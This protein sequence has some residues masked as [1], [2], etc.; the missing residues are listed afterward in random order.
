M[1]IKENLIGGGAYAA[2]SLEIVSVETELGFA[3]T[4]VEKDPYGMHGFA[5][6]DLGE[7][8]GGWDYSED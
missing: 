2:P 3:T 7:D 5:G 8:M 4:S 6:N 1:I